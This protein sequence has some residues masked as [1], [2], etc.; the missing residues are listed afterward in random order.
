MMARAEQDTFPWAAGERRVVARGQ[1]P[2]GLEWVELYAQDI[3][4]RTSYGFTANSAAEKSAGNFGFLTEEKALAEIQERADAG[5]F[6]VGVGP[7]LR[8]EPVRGGA[9]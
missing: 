7:M 5:C 8:V 4:G 3:N 9:R 6:H 2:S 1:T